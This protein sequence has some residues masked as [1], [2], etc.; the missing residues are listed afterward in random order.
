M[1][2]LG[3]QMKGQKLQGQCDVIEADLDGKSTV[4]YSDV[5]IPAGQSRTV[6]E[7]GRE[8]LTPNH[9]LQATMGGLGGNGPAR[10][11]DVASRAKRSERLQM[12]GR[13]RTCWC[14]AGEQDVL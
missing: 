14:G 1:N 5:G 10:W 7:S 12:T 2:Y 3:V 13:H 6:S 4:L 9:R 8:A 11:A